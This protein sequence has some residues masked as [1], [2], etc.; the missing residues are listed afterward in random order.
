MIVTYPLWG[1]LNFN[2]TLCDRR[3]TLNGMGPL[4][5]TQGR[6]KPGGQRMK[7]TLALLLS[8][9]RQGASCLTNTSDYP[10][11]QYHM[12]PKLPWIWWFYWANL[13]WAFFFSPLNHRP[14]AISSSSSG[15]LLVNKLSLMQILTSWLCVD[16]CA[17][18]IIH[19]MFLKAKRDLLELAVDRSVFPKTLKS[20]CK[21]TEWLKRHA[22]NRGS[23]KVR[24]GKTHRHHF[25]I[26]NLSFDCCLFTVPFLDMHQGAPV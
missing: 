21:T 13:C 16:S 11:S 18:N 4:E 6:Q 1:H 9:H 24:V 3:L 10:N 22:S 8:H 25:S 7:G 14:S 17:D 15:F 12:A 26:Y 2:R 5:E 19:G 20:G 23:K